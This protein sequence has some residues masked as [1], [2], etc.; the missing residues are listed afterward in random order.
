MGRKITMDEDD[1]AIFC[2]LLA[3]VAANVILYGIM[4]VR[5][6]ITVGA[7]PYVENFHFIF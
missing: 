7:M 6:L 4:F 2:I 3:I 5:F 1:I